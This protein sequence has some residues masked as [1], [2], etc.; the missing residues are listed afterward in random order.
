MP[1]S[2]S[3]INSLKVDLQNTQRCKTHF[4][5]GSIDQNDTSAVCGD[6]RLGPIVLPSC[7][8]LTSILDG[9]SPYRRFGGLCPRQFLA[10][11]TNDAPGNAPGKFK[12]PYADG[13]ANDTSSQPIRGSMTLEPGVRVD[14]FGSEGGTYVAPAGSPYSQRALPPTNLNSTIV[15]GKRV[16]ANYHVYEVKKS[17]VVIGGPTAPWFNQSGYGTQFQLPKRIAELVKE[18][19]LAELKV[20]GKCNDFKRAGE[21]WAWSHQN[22][23]LRRANGAEFE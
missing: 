16:P 19:V 14:R 7:M 11:W 10:S 1:P 17:L 9:T 21:E 4:C 23:K 8:P 2:L 5:A 13:F 12:Y 6:P 3:E 18:G 22:G 20:D 15:N